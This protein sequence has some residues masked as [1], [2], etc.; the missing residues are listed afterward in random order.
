MTVISDGTKIQ[1]K[2]LPAV[3]VT[4]LVNLVMVLNKINAYLVVDFKGLVYYLNINII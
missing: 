4:L 2:P 3:P 1:I